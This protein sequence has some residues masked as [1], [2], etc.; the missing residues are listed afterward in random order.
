M[1]RPGQSAVVQVLF[2]PAT[3]GGY[4]ATLAVTGSGGTTA[5]VDLSGTGLSA[6]GLFSATPTSVKF[7][8]VPVGR[9]VTKIVTLTNTGNEP[10][11][12]TT[13]TTLN[14][15]FTD[16]PNVTAGLPVNAGYDVRIPVTFT[17]EKKG[18]F[19]ATYRLTWTDVT[20]AHIIAVHISGHAG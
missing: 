2:E 8:A 19:T 1:L 7:A 16:Q 4:P 13:A 15:P 5:T 14:S 20:G 12:V 3:P 17:P 18:S 9:K 10:A 6:R 11:T